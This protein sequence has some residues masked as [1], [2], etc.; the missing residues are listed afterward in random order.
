M[1]NRISKGAIDPHPGGQDV[2]DSKA[3]AKVPLP[4]GAAAGIGGVEV[5]IEP[6][7]P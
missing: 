3:R 5:V 1:T 6:S 7:R 4:F 2:V